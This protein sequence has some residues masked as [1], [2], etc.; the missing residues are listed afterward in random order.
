M[1]YTAL[2]LCILQIEARSWQY[3]NSGILMRKHTFILPHK[4]VGSSV[5]AMQ[6]PACSSFAQRRVGNS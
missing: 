4:E 6:M 2:K 5:P 1:L 3:P